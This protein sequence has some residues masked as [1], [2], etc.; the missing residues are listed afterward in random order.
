MQNDQEVTCRILPVQVIHTAGKFQSIMAPRS[1]PALNKN[2]YAQVM[3]ISSRPD[4]WRITKNN[5][6]N[7]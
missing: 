2:H 7:E 1:H 4:V 3:Q 6:H 5:N